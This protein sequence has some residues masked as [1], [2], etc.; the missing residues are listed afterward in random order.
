MKVI[1]LTNVSK[2]FN[3][4][5]TKTKI[6]DNISLTIEKGEFVILQGENGSG[7]STL[8]NIILGLQRPDEGIVKLFNHSPEEPESKISV[9]CMLQKA[10]VPDS[11][12]VE[13]LINLFRSYYSNS[14]STEEVLRRVGLEHK[15]FDWAAKLSG[16]QEQLLYFSLAVAGNPELLILDEPTRSLDVTANSNFWEQ[17]RKFANQGKTILVVTHNQADAE[18]FTG[19]KRRTLKLSNGKI[20][21]IKEIQDTVRKVHQDKQADSGGKLG[22]S[23]T[24]LVE[25]TRYEFLELFRKPTFLLGIL[26]TSLLVAFF[27]KNDPNSKLYLVGLCA[28]NLLLIAIDK[29]GIR[30][31]TERVQGW[32][33]ILR[34]TPLPP[35]IYLTA[36]MLVFLVVAMVSLGLMLALAAWRVGIVEPLSWW[37]LLF[38]SLVLGVLP[39]AIIGFALGYLVEPKSISSITAL[40]LPIG[41]FTSGIPLLGMPSFVQDLIAI[42]PFY[43]YAQLVLWA[44][45]RGSY[46]GYLGLHLEWLLWTAYLASFLAVWAYRRDRAAE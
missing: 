3:K 45:I 7:K 42:S 30:V 41:L 27:P 19:L 23:L 39:F 29:F 9:G 31:A 5:S 40:V 2:S 22:N 17:V 25:Q 35:W 33:K 38:F 18:N 12:K 14:L 4:G 21:E 20:E 6:L 32:I 8:L 36:K 46:D 26:V 28:V 1:E 15:R 37:L 44:G 34:V 11:L 43:H 16:G 10:K 13:E 24:M